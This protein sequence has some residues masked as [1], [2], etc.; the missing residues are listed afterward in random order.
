M[1]IP[2]LTKLRDTLAAAP[3]ERFDIRFAF[4]RDGEPIQQREFTISGC[5]T[6]ACVLGWTAILFPD[7]DVR[8]PFW[9]NNRQASD[10]FT[11]PGYYSRPGYY[12]RARAVRT[13]TRLIAD[14]H[15]GEKAKVRWTDP[16]RGGP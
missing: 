16:A 3:D 2:N 10:L 15:L 11:P 9:L 14:A 4:S 12:T 7:E 13:L 6:A 1:N 5:G 8:L